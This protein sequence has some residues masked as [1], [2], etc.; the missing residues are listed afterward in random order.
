M[1]IIVIIMWSYIAP[2]SVPG[3]DP[4]HAVHY[5]LIDRHVQETQIYLL[6]A[7]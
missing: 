5:A 2:T 7:S 4:G 3:K 6:Q 1:L